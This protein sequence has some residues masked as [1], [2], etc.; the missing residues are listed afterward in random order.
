MIK[1]I[2]KK[3]LDKKGL[4]IVPKDE[5]NFLLTMLYFFLKRQ[6]KLFYVQIGANDGVSFDP[7]FNFVME[8]KEK[9]HGIVIEPSIDFY[10]Q[11]VENYKNLDNVK[12][13][14]IAIHNTEK[15]MDLYR[16]DKNKIEKLPD[17]TKGIGSFNKEHH[18]LSNLS[19]EFI[20]KE[21]VNC[22]S[23][24]ELIEQNNIENIDLLQIDTEGY[25]AEI[26]SNIDFNSIKPKLIHFE[27]GMR[28]G[29]MSRSTFDNVSAILHKNGYEIIIEP[30]DALAYNLN[31][32]YDYLTK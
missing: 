23:F 30:F 9:I 3:V 19:Q 18:N 24:K 2:I 14:N 20:V 1:N 7:I 21:S 27:H 31:T 22:I 11:L 4:K 12:K 13:L 16:V 17:W 15:K 28:E 26:I 5:V 25:D 29:V 8:N 6:N 32:F 10:N